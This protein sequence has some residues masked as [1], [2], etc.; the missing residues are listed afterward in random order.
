MFGFTSRNSRFSRALARLLVAGL[1][2]V[3]AATAWF[4]ASG[5]LP[6][7]RAGAARPAAR[8]ISF[9]TPPLTGRF[10]VGTLSLRLTDRS[11]LDPSSPSGVRELMVQFWYP[12]SRIGVTRLPRTCPRK[13]RGCSITTTRSRTI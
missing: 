7:A 13:S 11:R 5:S 3:A 1:P 9:Q 8:T 10:P 4:I 2:L 6:P 12:L